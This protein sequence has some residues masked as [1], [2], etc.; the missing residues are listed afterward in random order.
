MHHSFLF[1][2]AICLTCCLKAQRNLKKYVIRNAVSIET[3]D[4]DSTNYAD[5]E[6]IG[7]AIGNRTIVMLG[8]QDHGDA[9]TFIAK[10]RLIKYLHEKKGFNVLAFESD[11]FGLNY[12]IENVP[13][14]KNAIDTFLKKNIYPI[15]T[16]CNTCSELFYKYIPSTY[17]SAKRLRV[18]GFDNQLS[19]SYSREHL[20]AKLDSLLKSLDLAITKQPGYNSAVL[21][22][23]DSSLKLYWVKSKGDAHHARV[24]KYLKQIKSEVEEK[25]SKDDFWTMVVDNLIQENLEYY[26]QEKDYMQASNV[27]DLQMANNLK[28]IV[29]SKYPSEK[30]IV[31]AANAHVAKYADTSSSDSNK[32]WIRMG[33]YFTNDTSLLKKVYIIGF[34]SNEGQAGRLGWT[35]F[36]I[37]KPKANGFENWIHK[38]FNYAYVDFRG[39]NGPSEQ[40][41]MK[42][43]G[44]NTFFKWDWTQVFDG[45]FYIKQ[46][47]P[48]AR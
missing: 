21:P 29:N 10:T 23:I 11:F 15:W 6:A 35:V 27:R 37:R 33:S 26:L 18:S 43:L 19:L 36:K 38:S 45:I 32:K 1:V 14:D 20:T 12:G 2:I 48:C 30:I 5:L 24:D 46:M 39:F 41:Y 25:L 3:V 13:R 9:P 34:T 7:A 22:A 47:Y 31:W 42:G 4:P 44:H 8:E 17:A 16:E 28:W 40:F